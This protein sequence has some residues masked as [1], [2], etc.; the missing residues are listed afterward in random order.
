MSQAG[1]WAALRAA[2]AEAHATLESVPL[3]RRLFAEDFSQA[4]LTGLLNR[5]VSVYRPLERRLVGVE[6][7]L[8][9]VYRPRLPLLL[10]GLAVLGAAA[11][12][13]DIPAPVLDHDDARLGALY[14]IEGS[15]MGGQM[16]HQQLSARHPAAALAV[17]LPH[18][19]GAGEAWR[20]FRAALDT[21]LTRPEALERA[22]AAAIATFRMF[23]QALS[24]NWS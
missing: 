23:H 14:V 2:T 13:A 17:F 4:E 3:N 15:S 10:D 16:I 9:L 1:A 5:M 8:S 20:A 6:P 19:D 7:A 11:T 22:T 21:R 24:A 12:A 18:G